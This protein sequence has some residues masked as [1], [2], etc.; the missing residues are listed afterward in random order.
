V[1]SYGPS[2]KVKAIVL[3]S[4][5]EN[6]FEQEAIPTIFSFFFYFFFFFLKL[7]LY[8]NFIFIIEEFYDIYKTYHL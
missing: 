6:I 5:H 7:K 1:Y 8:K 2:S 3:F 4:V